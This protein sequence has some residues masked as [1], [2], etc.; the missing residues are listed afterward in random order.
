MKLNEVVNQNP[1]IIKV[2]DY[3]EN[4]QTYDM[5]TAT[6]GHGH[7]HLTNDKQ[8]WFADT[9]N[10]EYLK[11]PVEPNQPTVSTPDYAVYSID[12]N[13]GV[14]DSASMVK[15]A[16]ARN[17]DDAWSKLYDIQGEDAKDMEGDN[18]SAWGH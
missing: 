1:I 10:N 4:G 13:F 14:Y 3:A 5:W 11:E 6:D 17:A 15:Y 9:P 8:I 18:D 16:D 7:Y 12:G 2:T